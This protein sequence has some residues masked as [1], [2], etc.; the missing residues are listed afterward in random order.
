MAQIPR[1]LREV[2]PP[3]RLFLVR[4]GE[5]EGDG[6][7]HGHTDVALT[8]RGFAQLE[9]VAERLRAE[10]LAAVYSSDLQRS[11]IGAE[12]MARGRDVP[13]RHDPVFR[14]LHMGEWDGRSVGELWDSDRA[15]IQGWWAD[16]ESFVI[17]GG[18]SLLDLKAR[19]M[20]A[21]G[22]LLARHPGESVCLVAHGGVNRVILFEAL[23]LPLS[24]YHKLAQDY[25]CLNII[26][27]YRDGNTV[28]SLVNG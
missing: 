15:R 4:H 6:F 28:I 2:G 25:G 24:Q 10:P 11:R 9:T 21:L 3:T 22:D 14:E 20:G 27:Y 1:R 17:P 23:G 13:V 16:L 7:L 26:D 12:L 19:I 8:A 5:V 18:E